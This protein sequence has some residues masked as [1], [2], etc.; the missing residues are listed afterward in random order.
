MIFTSNFCKKDFH[1]SSKPSAREMVEI[2]IE[3]FFSPWT[4]KDYMEMQKQSS[5]NSWLLEI[6]DVSSVGILAFNSVQPELEILRLGI[7]PNWR[8]NG[9]AELM[10]EELERFSKKYKMD[11]IW[12]EVD[13]SNKPAKSLY[14][15][16]GFKE[17]NIRKGYFRNRLGD[18]LLLKKSL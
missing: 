9:L 14:R 10:L 12:L 15:K 11:S 3:C 17:M 2:E 7:H 5:F 16:T 6:P 1:I 13:V 4:E 18:A 8:K